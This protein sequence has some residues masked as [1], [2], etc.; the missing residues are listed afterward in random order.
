MPRFWNRQFMTRTPRTAP[1]RLRPA[2][3]VQ[4]ALKGVLDAVNN[5][6]S[7]VLA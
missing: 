7:I 6:E 5:N 3:E 1:A 4:E 2:L